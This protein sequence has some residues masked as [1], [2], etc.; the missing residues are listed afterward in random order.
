MIELRN[1]PGGHFEKV[2]EG[3][4]LLILRTKDAAARVQVD[5]QLRVAINALRL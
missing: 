2:L 3:S 5:A 4:G 1:C